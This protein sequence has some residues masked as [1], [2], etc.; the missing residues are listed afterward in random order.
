VDTDLSV[1]V[2][3]PARKACADLASG[4]RK[5]RRAPQDVAPAEVTSQLVRAV[6][7][8]IS[9]APAPTTLINTR[10]TVDLA[11]RPRDEGV[12][13]PKAPHGHFLA[14]RLKQ[15]AD[16]EEQ[17]ELNTVARLYA[18]HGYATRLAPDPVALT[19]PVLKPLRHPCHSRPSRP[20]NVIE[21]TVG[22]PKT[23]LFTTVAAVLPIAEPT[24]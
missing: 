2:P 19:A 16:S 3:N 11:V 14:L 5:F 12:L 22:A 15:R 4:V 20:G 9:D 24:D 8:T 1:R 17:P 7:R 23:N 10:P 18:L 21:D 13:E 6:R